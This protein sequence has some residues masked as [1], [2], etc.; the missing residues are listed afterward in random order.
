MEQLKT[1]DEK[2]KAE[3]WLVLWTAIGWKLDHDPEAIL[4]ATE[5][6][7]AR[8][9]QDDPL[10]MHFVETMGMSNALEEV[11]Q[12]TAQIRVVGSTH[13]LGGW[14]TPALQFQGELAVSIR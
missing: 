5:W 13:A 6:L 14:G 11:R 10:A 2:K 1:L 12:Y 9:G 3:D 8:F 4:Q 7:M